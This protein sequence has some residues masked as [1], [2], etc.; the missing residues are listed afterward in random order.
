[1]DNPQS[2]IQNPQSLWWRDGIIY[3]IYP[4]S[5]ADSQR[6][7]RG[8]PARHHV[9]VGLSA[10]AGRGCHLAQPDLSFADGRLW[11]RREQLSRH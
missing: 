11:L 3:Q 5:F 4:R 8:R 9:Q 7:W 1:M 6:R 10:L 2:A